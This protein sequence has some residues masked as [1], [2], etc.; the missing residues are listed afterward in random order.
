MQKN[1]DFRQELMQWHRPGLRCAYTPKPEE[2]SLEQVTVLLP[3]DA[4]E[5]LCTA[6]QDFQDYPYPDQKMSLLILF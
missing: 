5:V 2:V 6:A 4:G 1:Y 3:P